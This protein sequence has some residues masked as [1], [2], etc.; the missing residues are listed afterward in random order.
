MSKKWIL[1]AFT[2]VSLSVITAC[3]GESEEEAGS[4]DE[5]GQEAQQEEQAAE[6]EDAAQSEQAEQPEQPEQL[7][8]NLDDV[9]DVVADVNG[10]EVT[11]DEFEVAYT[12]ALSMYSMQGMNLEEQD[13]NGEMEAELKQAAADQLVG[14]ELLIQ[15]AD[16]REYSADEQE[17]DDL[18][19]EQKEQFESDDQYQ[20]ALEEQGYTEDE[21]RAEVEQ[22][23][24]VE[25]LIEEESQDLE[26]TEE[27]IDEA[28]AQTE[29][30]QAAMAEQA[31]EE[32]PEMPE[33]DREQ[34]EEQLITQKQAESAQEL[35]DQLREDGDVTVHI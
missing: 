4:A 32:A 2:A 28:V 7:E 9:P 31:G 8:P 21:F 10:E 35:I 11:K 25:Q 13:E 34:I 24:K 18:I 30:Q 17:V 29:E 6:G 26:V 15:E 3:G 20:Q 27:E 14:Q 1:T 12:S 5:S 19:A 16:E 23:I 33:P 22:S